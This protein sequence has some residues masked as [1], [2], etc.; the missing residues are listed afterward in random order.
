MKGIYK[1]S[2]TPFYF[3]KRKTEESK[4]KHD[5]T[6]QSY[7]IKKV[8]QAVVDGILRVDSNTVVVLVHPTVTLQEKVFQGHGV[9]LFVGNHQLVVEAKQ[10]ELQRFIAIA[11]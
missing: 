4:N 1:D 5:S 10:D 11:R 8:K 9:F 2:T 7:P 6:C 3:F